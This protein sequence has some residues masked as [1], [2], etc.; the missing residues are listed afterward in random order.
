M[1]RG[2]LAAAVTPLRDGGTRLDED[3]FGPVTDFLAEGGLDGILA[4][5]TT[6][7][8]ILLTAEERRRAAELY[9]YACRGRLEVAVHCGAQTTGETVAL[10]EHAASAGASA[11]AVIPPPY[12]PLSDESLFEH[13]RAAAQACAPVAFFLYEFEARSGYAIPLG[14]IERL[15]EAAPNLAGLKVSDTPFD[16]VQPYLLEGLDIF[17]GSE[18]LLPRGKAQG[19]AGTVSGLAAAFPEHVAALNRDPNAGGA[20]ELVA[21]LRDALQQFQFNAAVKAALAWRGVPLQGDVRAPLLPLAD[22]ERSALEARLE[23]LTG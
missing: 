20:T 6:G 2:S 8:G 23:E 10:A 13:F 4:L 17:I 19:A 15:R 7:E 5:G 21:A 16:R 22:E 12:F 14:V 3:A 9:L 11:V 1:L 18:P